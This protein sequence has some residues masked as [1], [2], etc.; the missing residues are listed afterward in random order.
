M[1]SPKKKEEESSSA[2]AKGRKPAELVAARA[3]PSPGAIDFGVPATSAALEWDTNLEIMAAGLDARAQGVMQANARVKVAYATQNSLSLLPPARV[4]QA[5]N[6]ARAAEASLQ[7]AIEDWEAA[8]AALS[9]GLSTVLR[10]GIGR[11]R[12]LDLVATL[13]KEAQKAH[14]EVE[15]TRSAAVERALDDGYSG[16]CASRGLVGRRL[17]LHRPRLLPQLRR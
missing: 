12:L 13:R 2:P 3:A 16:H 10:Y 14:A 11:P 6:A 4:C 9:G 8:A 15:F 7:L 1:E 5:S 17:V